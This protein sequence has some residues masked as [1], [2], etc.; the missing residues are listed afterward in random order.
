[1]RWFW[2]TKQPKLH[3]FEKHMWAGNNAWIA[4]E[5]LKIYKAED[6]LFP[7]FK[8]GM[9]HFCAEKP[10][11]TYWWDKHNG[12]NVLCDEHWADPVLR[13]S[14]VRGQWVGWEMDAAYRG[15]PFGEHVDGRPPFERGHHH[16][17]WEDVL[18]PLSDA[19]LSEGPPEHDR[20]FRIITD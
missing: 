20:R 10:T 18:A 2:Q 5:T 1:M 6:L 19:V 8:P 9:C 13:Y 17:T 14:F 7:L 4:E 11:G 12:M 3:P 16:A 15:C